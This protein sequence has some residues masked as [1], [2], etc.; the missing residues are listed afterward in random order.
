MIKFGPSGFCQDFLLTHKKSE[1][2]PQWLTENGL[3]A[4]EVSFTNGIVMGDDKCSKLGN[5]FAQHNI[6]L[7][8]HAP[9]YI[10]FANPNPEMIEK[11]FGYIIDSLKKMK[12][13]GA[14]KL[15]FHPGSL[16]KQTREQALENI[17]NNLKE[18]IKRIDEQ[19]FDFEFYICPE[20]MGKHGQCGT[21]AEIAQMCSIDKRIIPTLDFGHINSFNQGSLKTQEDFE[22]VFKVLQNII[23][24][25]YKFVHIHF[26]KIEY[27]AKGEIRH[28]TFDTDDLKYGPNYEPMIAALKAL[29]IT[30]NVICESNGSQTKDSVTMHK[31]Y[32]QI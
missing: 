20:T 27:G 22:Y 10:N 11:S 31:L 19:N 7:S 4:Y 6:E 14:K 16:T 8:V 13:L 28:L 18:L 26:S 9:Y 32:M 15:V 1:D 17:L 21:V 29:D 12:L 25:R 5:L 30:A 3:S 23:G 24:D 2:M